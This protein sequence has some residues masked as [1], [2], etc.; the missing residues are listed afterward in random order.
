MKNNKLLLSALVVLSSAALCTSCSTKKTTIKNEQ[1]GASIS[2]YFDS[3]ARQPEYFEKFNEAG[4]ILI[5]GFEK[6][7]RASKYYGLGNLGGCDNSAR[8]SS[9]KA[10]GVFDAIARSPEIS[11]F[12][13]TV[14]IAKIDLIL[15]SKTDVASEM[16]GLGAGH[17]FDAVARQP[18]VKD[19]LLT[20][21][22]Y[23]DSSMLE[24]K[25]EDNAYAIGCASVGFY[26]SVAR[27][28]EQKEVLFD[29]FKDFIDS[30][31]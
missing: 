4:S 15:G 25:K 20:C 17:L 7:N 21:S 5:D 14:E 23:I 13:I 29:S 27:Q 31:K 22:E 1:L 19:Y 24:A 16:I 11:D 6:A 2:N 3:A 28:P 8:Y 9:S 10:S 26:S 30:L 18:G 12:V